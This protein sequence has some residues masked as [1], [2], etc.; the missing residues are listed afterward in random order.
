MASSEKAA[1]AGVKI[2]VAGSWIPYPLS[3]RCG[4]GKWLRDLHLDAAENKRQNKE[5]ESLVNYK[6][7]N[8]ESVKA[9]DSGREK[10]AALYLYHVEAG[11]LQSVFSVFERFSGRFAQRFE[12]ANFPLDVQMLRVDIEAARAEQFSFWKPAHEPLL[13]LPWLED[14]TKNPSDEESA[15]YRKDKGK[16]F[17]WPWTELVQPAA[18]QQTATAKAQPASGS[19]V[20]VKEKAMPVFS[21]WQSFGVVQEHSSKT[22]AE[23]SRSGAM[24]DKY[25]FEV[26]VARRPLRVLVSKALPT[27][28]MVS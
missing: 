3:M 19:F 7:A 11:V 21:E 5:V 14:W 18:A 27:F 13:L 2:Q 22:P 25:V 16:P 28:L 6:A 24:Y 4:G 9:G 17:M 10:W 1:E 8:F 12:L 23:H 26:A 20:V 15:A